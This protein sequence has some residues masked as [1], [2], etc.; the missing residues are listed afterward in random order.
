MIKL[1]TFRGVA[2]NGDPL[3]QIFR[4]DRPLAKIAGALMPS[5]QEWMATYTSDPNKIAILVNALGASEY[6][7]QNVN[8]DIFPEASLVHDCSKHT[9]TPHPFDDFTGKDVPAYGAWT[10]KE[11]AKPY[12]HH[13]NKDPNRAFGDVVHWCWNPRMHRVE[14][15]VV[16]DR[17][18]ALQNG[19]A[20]V[21]DRIDA[22]EYPDVSMGCLTAGTLITLADGTRRPIEEV[23]AGD[24]VLTHMG[25][26]RRVT[27]VHKRL[28]KGDLYTVRAEAHEPLRCTRDHPFLT[29]ADSE[30]K[31]SDSY[32]RW[33]ESNQVAIRD[34]AHTKCLDGVH[35]LEPVLDYEDTLT[36]DYVTRA[37][38]RLFG[39]YLA[40]GHV[41][42]NHQKEVVGV[43]FTTHKDDAIH[44]E[45]SDLCLEFGTK[46]SPVSTPRANSE[47]SV[48]ITVF[49]SRL[50]GLCLQ[51]GGSYAKGKK[52]SEE[53]L[54]WHP[55]AW[56]DIV[57]AYANGDGCGSNDGSLGLSTASTNLAWQFVL[58]L[59]KLGII[60]SICNLTHKAGS[61]FS[62]GATYEWVIHIGK[63]HAQKLRG[64]CAK[65]KPVEIL[66]A[67]VGRKIFVARNSSPPDEASTFVVTPIRDYDSIYAEVDV[68][69]LEVEE[70]ESYIA[71]GLAM[72]NCKVPYDI[73][74]IC[75][76]RSKTRYDYCACVKEIGMGTIL[77]DGRRIGVI[78][79]YPRF[80]DISFVFIGAD[81]TA[82]VMVKLGS[83][84]LVPLSAVEGEKIYGPDQGEY[85]V[86]A[87]G[88][89][90]LT[91]AEE[92][93]A[94]TDRPEQHF[95]S[96]GTLED[97]SGQISVTRHKPLPEETTDLMLGNTDHQ[98]P[99][100][101]IEDGVL[102]TNMNSFG[103]GTEKD[104]AER[105]TMVKVG[106]DVKALFEEAKKIKI[107]PPPMPNRDKY[108]FVGT[109]NFRGLEIGVENA[110]G[111]W[112]TGKDWKTLMKLPYGE[113][114]HRKA[115]G[116]DQDKIDVYVGPYVDAP[117]IYVIH[118]N[119][120]HGPEKGHYD[121]DKIM[122]GCKSEA[123]AKAAYLAHYDDDRYFRSIT[124]MS[125]PMFKRALI[126]GEVNGEKV[127][128]IHDVLGP[129]RGDL[130][131][132]D[133]FRKEAIVTS[134]GSVYRLIDMLKHPPEDAPLHRWVSEDPEKGS[135]F[136][137][138]AHGAA[139]GAHNY[140]L[141]RR[142]M[143]T[144][145]PVEKT[146][147]TKEDLNP[148]HGGLQLEDLFSNPN[149][150]RRQRTWRDKVT[151]RET[152]VVGS[153]MTRDEVKTASV[154]KRAEP[155]DPLEILKLSTSTKAADL[156]KWSDIVK[157]IGPDKATGKVTELLD[158]AEPSIPAEALDTMGSKC[159]LEQA[160]ATPS[161]MGMVL[162]PEE[163]Q[164]IM[165]GHLGKPELADSLAKAKM[166]FPQ[167]EGMEAPCGDLSVGD[168]LPKLMQ[169]LMPL[170]EQK[171]YFGPVV[172]RRII[173]VVLQTPEP[174]EPG[175]EL[176]SPILS[177][178]ASAYNWYRREQIK[179]AMEA[180]E[181]IQTVPSLRGGVYDL[182]AYDLFTEKTASDLLRAGMAVGTVPLALMYSAHLR[183]QQAMG[184]PQGTMKQM[185]GEHPWLSALGA[186]ALSR[187]L[188]G[189]QAGRDI[190]DEIGNIGKKLWQGTPGV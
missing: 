7:G 169:A 27:K 43:E 112:R 30:V 78:N 16:L 12:C 71:A 50:A 75:G 45:I 162:K 44:Q 143:S 98:D 92:Q 100:E 116:M 113:F 55:D 87:A 127:A 90:M 167:S 109:I 95:T 146:A 133:M 118:Q 117:N 63:Q 152:S 104:E 34:W 57:G 13:K 89:K 82:K 99:V 73:C 48:G 121:E 176:K 41:L 40:E 137:D 61:G 136:A 42:R 67:K 51:H 9:G 128:S 102:R 183:D 88:S 149:A 107:G 144:P 153:G 66:K 129:V 182:D 97:G 148:I 49:D 53:A 94:G 158:K 160:L 68:Y 14:L 106:E 181:F 76:N 24:R 26:A 159:R 126:G 166:V 91:F 52:I 147:E 120:V 173:K 103:T 28:Y 180:P 184:M 38:S 168:F 47:N 20:H 110:A 178:V 69:N 77:K 123:Q 108:P 22:G 70:D 141:G 155:M 85:L 39:Y 131:I 64:F 142:G 172:R 189:T 18:A 163:F 80:F 186:A 19:A 165:L 145:P 84:L 11:Y 60:A 134:A 59:S 58:I 171:S 130:R 119:H 6:W 132:E 46:N 29:V 25:R 23:V 96:R 125:F 83:G 187:S 36:P 151:D 115:K 10:F 124:T 122:L 2:P 79:T 17:T 170:L 174:T 56:M 111:T 15:I 32:R 135:G 101:A 188:L 74:T 1:A 8:G 54:H 86:K 33:K 161:L 179:L 154:V 5:V 140:Y 157:E 139:H 138:L 62:Y 105:V 175:S 31:T 93:E 72:H 150:E 164:R 35:L 190:S 81:K 114:L 21:I 37:F 177:K 4:P 3:V 156:Q 185:I 65:V